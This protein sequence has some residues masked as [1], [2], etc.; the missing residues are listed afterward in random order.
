MNREYP[1]EE[2]FL[3]RLTDWDERLEKGETIQNAPDLDSKQILDQ[4][5]NRGLACL[6]K[7][8]SIRRRKAD[9]PTTSST[10]ISEFNFTPVKY[11]LPC[12]FGK[13]D[14]LSEL[15]RGGFGVVFLA[16]D[17]VL[18]CEVAL[19][20]PHSHVLTNDSL[21]ERFLREARVAAG[22][23]HPNIVA[24]HEAG[25]M[26]P[27]NYIVYSYCAGITLGDWIRAQKDQIPAQQAA[28]W[29]ASLADAVSFAHSKGV[30]HRDLKPSNILLHDS[31]S[32]GPTI[33]TSSHRTSS[34]IPK[35]T[36]FGLAKLERE[37][38][39]TATGAILG[40]PCYMAPEQASGKN[41]IGNGVDIHALG[42]LL[43]ELLAG[44]PPYRGESDYE[45]LQLVSK[46]EPLPLR[47]LRPKLSKDLDTICLKCLQKDPAL[48]YR[49]AADLAADLRRYLRGEP[50]HARPVS[51]V[52]RSWRLC[53]RHPL[54]TGLAAALLLA[55]VSGI[56][57]IAYQNH[58]RGVQADATKA[59]LHKH[60]EFLR[61]I[62]T[63]AQEM[64]KDVRTEKQGREKLISLLP[65]F[66]ALL[67]DPQTEPSLQLE[68]ARLASQVGSIH[69]TLAEYQKSSVRYQQSIDLFEQLIKKHGASSSLLEEEASVLSRLAFS[70]RTLK[71]HAESEKLY[72]RA[73]SQMMDELQK[74]PENTK[75]MAFI[76]DALVYNCFNLT[77]MERLAEVE[78][79]LLLAMNHIEKALSLKPDDDR[80]LL[81]QAIVFDDLGW[82][83]MSVKRMDE[84]DRH[85]QNA[86][87]IRQAVFERSPKQLGVAE[88]LARS[89]WR[90]GVYSHRQGLWKESEEH[91]KTS[92]NMNDQMMKDHP[93]APGIAHN[94]AWDRVILSNLLE[95]D[96]IKRYEDA[97]K[98]FREAIDIRKKCQRD[99]PQH[100]LNQFE[101]VAL[102]FRLSSNLRAQSK[103]IEAD[104]TYLEGLS[105]NERLIVD[106]PKVTRHREQYASRLQTLARQYETDRQSDKAADINQK[107]LQV[108][109]KLV[110]DYPDVVNYQR[111]LDASY[112]KFGNNYRSTKQWQKSSDMMA[113]IVPL[114]AR[115]LE[116]SGY[117]ARDRYTLAARLYLWGRDLGELQ[118][119]ELAIEK[120]QESLS[121]YEALRNDGQQIPGL[122]AD[123][124][125]ACMQLGYER[126][127]L[128]QM[129]LAHE[130]FLKALPLRERLFSAGK[131]VTTRNMLA[132]C[133]YM[134][135][136]TF[137]Y[138]KHDGAAA[139]EHY[140]LSSVIDPVYC[141]L[142]VDPNWLIKMAWLHNKITPRTA[143]TPS[144]SS[145][146]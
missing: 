47:K 46:Q 79:D 3:D 62:V 82:H 22:L 93:F 35:I 126:V 66:E 50:I 28:E 6:K 48:R 44:H 43:Y 140:V 119:H 69:Y 118:K 1:V 41:A 49:T 99:F 30:L 65:Y 137:W 88:A 89:H 110:E 131:T 127:T 98:L 56:A 100:E 8:D 71:K 9:T 105:L 81:T 129:L 52:E 96:K 76:A 7:L 68:A 32:N 132:K 27:V 83:C 139:I 13:F 40:T 115:I 124:G 20:M 120:L 29:V 33:V 109:E 113:R 102:H 4:K 18:D 143:S 136:Q 84:A 114:R 5:L 17:R 106:F 19:K 77:E 130:A 14:L 74:H 39:Q 101:L 37:K 45:T 94:A 60:L 75:A 95:E 146:K 63:D 64:M 116:G 59:W 144:A 51:W 112:T 61:T 104:E 25:S 54:V 135:F 34:F 133:H 15:G 125:H 138:V 117:S 26:G 42:V 90:V 122:I 97:E 80:L 23:S 78:Q 141:K 38:Q 10:K 86:L 12:H 55:T 70:Q 103:A 87:S 134:L 11:R 107:L 21:R 145:G 73:I 72:R 57:G 128:K 85:L 53:K 16:R 142:P 58:E 108:R 36:D 111:D 67:I 123:H 92:I 2:T 91:Y 121:H 31:Q 24:V